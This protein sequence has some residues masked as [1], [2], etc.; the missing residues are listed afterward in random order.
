[1]CV[2]G[3]SEEA[4]G[5]WMMSN[6]VRHPRSFRSTAKAKATRLLWTQ[7]WVLP[8]CRVELGKNLGNSFLTGPA[9]KEPV[10]N[11]PYQQLRATAPR[12]LCY[13][14]L[15]RSLLLQLHAISAFGKL[16]LFTVLPVLTV[17][18]LIHLCPTTRAQIPI[19]DLS[20]RSATGLECIMWP[21]WL[22]LLVV[23]CSSALNFCSFPDSSPFYIHADYSDAGS[24]ATYTDSPIF[25]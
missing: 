10:P 6:C 21:I 17:L 8:V 11:I 9:N 20:Q 25:P 18:V 23:F 22:R 5:P 16:L 1:M 13:F 7:A 14:C 24:S 15:G 2:G 3:W 4:S 19:I 12:S